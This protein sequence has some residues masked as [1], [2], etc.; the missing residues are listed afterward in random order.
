MTC[1]G[2]SGLSLCSSAL[3]TLKK[4]P[5]KMQRE[6]DEALRGGLLWLQR[7]ISVRYNPGP[8]GAWSNWHFYYLYG[9]ER[10]CELNQIALLGDT[11]WYFDGAMELLLRQTKEGTW[12][13]PENTCFGLLFLKKTAL[14][15]ITR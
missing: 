5:L 10:A 12:D 14:P 4:S 7:N 8:E 6:I 3:R 1:A 9:L 15:A 13:S 11:D 2:I